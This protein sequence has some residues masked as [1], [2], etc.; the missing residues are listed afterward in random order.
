MHLK[1]NIV[2]F[3]AQLESPND[4][5]D[6]RSAD[7]IQADL[8]TNL[9]ESASHLLAIASYEELLQQ[10]VARTADTLPM[11]Q[12]G[13]LWLYDQRSQRLQ[14]A[15]HHGLPLDSNVLPL[16]TSCQLSPGEGITGRAFESDDAVIIETN[17]IY[18]SFLE[19]LTARPRTEW[20]DLLRH[21]RDHLNRTVSLFCL[22]LRTNEETVGVLVLID[23]EQ[24]FDPALPQ[25]LRDET[26]PPAMRH[27][28]R[29][30]L[31]T[32]SRL[33]AT[34]IHNKQLYDQS[35]E[36]RQRLDA[37]DA[38]VTAISTATDLTDMLHSVL[39][40]LL[41]FLPVSSG[42]IFV[43]DPIQARLKLGA[44]TRLPDEYVATIGNFP[45]EDSPFEEV[46]NYGQPVLR[47][48]I[49]A[50]GEARLIESGLE[51]CA[52]LPL[53]AGGT[54]VG[55]LGLYGSATLHRELDMTRLMPLSNQIGFAI[56]NVRL[57][58][59]SYLERHKLNTVINSIAEGVVLCDSQGRLV[60]A[61]ET[62]MAL[63]SLEA[64]P[65]EQ[66][67]SE[68]ADF[69]LIRDLDNEPL[70][71]EH[72]PMARALAG[73]TFQDYRVK[74]HGVSGN[75]SVMSFSGAP[76]RA[77]EQTIEGAV[78]VF[79]DITARERL[80]RAK[81][82]FL[83]VT[84]HELRN[85]LAAVRSYADLLLRRE[86]QRT[87][88]GDSRDMHGLRVL[89]QQ[90]THMLRMVDN[91]L[92]VSRLDA[93]QVDLKTEWVDLVAL[94]EQVLDQQRPVA[95]NHTLELHTEQD[96]VWLACDE[97][98]VRQILTNLVSNAVK[99]SPPNRTVRV[100][101]GMRPVERETAVG[102]AEADEPQAGAAPTHVALLRVSDEGKG[103]PP[104]QQSRL[105]QR[106]YRAH[107]P[108]A[109]GLG[110]GLYL[111][112]QFVEL[113]G[114]RIK[115]DSIEGRGSTFSVTLPICTEPHDTA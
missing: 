97:L 30:L 103:I 40:V 2:G 19:H 8:M 86:Q 85:P 68:M 96:A 87:E 54:V 4:T 53:L 71:V 100:I 72:L 1:Q 63:L 34:V 39:H 46:A 20:R 80:E 67:V 82:D 50:R 98:R 62:A 13:M 79:R 25:Q 110:L 64:V 21:L 31:P 26:A 105:F 9:L 52:Y 66:H 48:L 91:L 44:Y 108:G 45:I 84:A 5:T 77:D 78:V 12:A 94:A 92:D 14:L 76:I 32:F 70:P 10:S 109:E 102:G 69:Y 17:I 95:P 7:E 38:V 15:A 73:E 59:D 56:A 33:I 49:D 112:R 37:F 11:V 43:L 6:T 74:L 104:D 55:T 114:G 35:Q 22:P 42:A 89:S 111:S 65:F 88:S 75:N 83:A 41:G 51:S 61:N 24:S 90:V 93:G 16:L 27:L 107:R 28:F 47:P 81:D 106:F 36:H 23:F 58:E 113:H 3:D 57:Y 99:Y 60:L 29:Q 18:T 115:V 101:V